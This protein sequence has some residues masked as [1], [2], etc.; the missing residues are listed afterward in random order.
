M[1]KMIGRSYVNTHVEEYFKENCYKSSDG[2]LYLILDINKEPFKDN[3]S[4]I[5]KNIIEDDL[6]VPKA[7]FCIING[8][9][10]EKKNMV[11][12]TDLVHIN[13]VVYEVIVGVI[14]FDSEWH[15][16]TFI[17]ID[18]LGN[19]SKDYSFGMEGVENRINNIIN[20]SLEMR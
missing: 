14:P 4:S 17:R 9:Y 20:V 6:S 13:G 18:F 3:C 12:K 1:K 5:E 16:A 2:L 10:T 11:I 8:H 19:I 15:D 7:I